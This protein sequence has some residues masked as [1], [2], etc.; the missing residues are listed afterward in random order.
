MHLVI[1]LMFLTGWILCIRQ[2]GGKDNIFGKPIGPF[3]QISEGL[4]LLL[5]WKMIK[6]LLMRRKQRMQILLRIRRIQLL[7]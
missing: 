2:S 6:R 5:N 1:G 4:Y 7:R 3:Y